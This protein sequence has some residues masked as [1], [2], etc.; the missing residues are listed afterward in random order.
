MAW[1]FASSFSAGIGSRG[2]IVAVWRM[3]REEEKW[4]DGKCGR[5]PGTFVV[6]Q[7]RGFAPAAFALRAFI[8]RFPWPVRVAVE[9]V[10]VSRNGRARVD[11]V[12]T[13]DRPHPCTA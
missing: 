5:T 12:I 7:A 10:E 6:L 8:L 4:K 2:A 3:R 13:D 9:G 1:S 11:E